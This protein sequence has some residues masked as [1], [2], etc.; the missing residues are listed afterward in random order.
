LAAV[1]GGLLIAILWPL[2]HVL[3]LLII[4]G[5]MGRVAPYGDNA[6]LWIATGVV[7]FM[8]FNHMARFIMLGIV[9]NRPLL[10][11][12][13]VKIMD[14]LFARAIVEVLNAAVIILILF[15]IF[16]V[17]GVD[18]MPMDLVQ[19][20]LALLAMM[21]FGV[22]FGLINGIIAAAFPFWI[23]ASVLLQILL[24]LVS[25]VLFVP[26]VLPEQITAW[27]AYLPTLQ[28]VEWMRSAYYE[29]YGS[30]I[31]DRTLALMEDRAGRKIAPEGFERFFHHR[32]RFAGAYGRMVFKRFFG[33]VGS[34]GVETVER[35][36]LG[37]LVGLA[38]IGQMRI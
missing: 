23:T 35:G 3:I 38:A 25:G 24:W 27:L 15:A 12:P 6:A 22:S 16:W 8:A 34:H 14:I 11:F 18:F 4:N 33:Q 20:S 1:N 30:S 31:L 21:L 17:Y 10:F 7:P 9:V 13:V 26:E 5:A 2:S 19:A 28:G 37:D 32:E 29:G 36:F